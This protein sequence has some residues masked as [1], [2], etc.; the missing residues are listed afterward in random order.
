MLFMMLC[1]F[2]LKTKTFYDK[3]SNTCRSFWSLVRV[4]RCGISPLISTRCVTVCH[5]AMASEEQ[6]LRI[7][8]CFCATF[9]SSTSFDHELLIF[10]WDF[11]AAA[12]S[13]LLP[14]KK[15]RDSRELLLSTWETCCLLLLVILQILLTWPSSAIFLGRWTA[16]WAEYFNSDTVGL[17]K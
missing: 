16:V 9:F 14:K 10:F 13:R 1:D 7:N 11:A 8:V 4:Y 12:K 5:H 2:S 15:N 17:A 3:P 6:R